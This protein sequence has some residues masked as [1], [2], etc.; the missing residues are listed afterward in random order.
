MGITPFLKSTST[1]IIS[2]ARDMAACLQSWELFARGRWTGVWLTGQCP[3]V[4]GSSPVWR[5]L[6]ET[7]EPGLHCQTSTLFNHHQPKTLDS[8]QS[9][10]PNGSPPDANS[11]NHLTLP[12]NNVGQLWQCTTEWP[13]CKRAGEAIE[14]QRA[15]RRAVRPPGPPIAAQIC[16][17]RPH[18]P[19][20]SRQSWTTFRECPTLMS[21]LTM[22]PLSTTTAPSA[23]SQ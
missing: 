19:C 2:R 9:T 18:R 8:P 11:I 12:S 4:F 5:H 21:T 16:G 17:R 1:E 22:S 13:H 20:G 15:F 6:K 14:S 3:G 10:T 7:W 23:P